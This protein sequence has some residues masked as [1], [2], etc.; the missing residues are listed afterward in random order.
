M[1][2]TVECQKEFPFMLYISK[3]LEINVSVLAGPVETSN[4]NVYYVCD[5]TDCSVNFGYLF[6][7]SALHVSR[8]TFCFS[9]SPTDV[10]TL[11]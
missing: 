9:I 10:G 1:I 3:F 6:E 11:E 8:G 4:Q 7:V 2:C 5:K